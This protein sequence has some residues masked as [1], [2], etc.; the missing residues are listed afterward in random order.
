MSDGS[1]H[2]LNNASSLWVLLVLLLGPQV[3]GLQAAAMP[4]WLLH[5]SGN[6][7]SDLGAYAAEASSQ[8]FICSF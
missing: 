6:P 2:T 3:L 8:A 1:A 4:A 7:H 5:G